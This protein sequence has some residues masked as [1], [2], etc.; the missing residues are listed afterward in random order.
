MM[1][2]A[3]LRTMSQRTAPRP[4]WARRLEIEVNTMVAMAVAIAIFTDR[5]GPTPR[6]SR[7]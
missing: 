5:S 6:L 2:G 3:R 1:P 7:K 4:W